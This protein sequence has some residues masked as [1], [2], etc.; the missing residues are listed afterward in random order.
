MSIQRKNV[1]IRKIFTFYYSGNSQWNYSSLISS[2][3]FGFRWESGNLHKLK[4]TH[5]MRH[6]TSDSH[7]AKMCPLGR[8]YSAAFTESNLLST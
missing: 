4:M 1:D 6:Q 2:L 8:F 3:M 5:T 7:D